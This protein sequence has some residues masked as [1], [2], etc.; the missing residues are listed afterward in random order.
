METATIDPR[1]RLGRVRLRVRD[2]RRRDGVLRAC[3]RPLWSSREHDRVTLGAA[4]GAPLVELL[5]RPADHARTAMTGPLPSGASCRTAESSPRR[6]A[7]SREAGWSFTGAGS[8]VSE[9]VYLRDP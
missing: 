6:S 1:T 3:D 7:A 5:H 9:A 8:S 4:D 2:L